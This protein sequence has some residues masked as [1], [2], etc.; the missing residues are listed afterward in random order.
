MATQP[1][2]DRE[3]PRVVGQ[4]RLGR[5]A[6]P[7]AP[8]HETHVT[9]RCRARRRARSARASGRSA[10]SSAAPRCTPRRRRPSSARSR[11]RGS[12]APRRGRPRAPGGA[13]RRSRAR[14]GG[15]PTAAFATTRKSASRYAQIIR[16]ID[17]ADAGERGSGERAQRHPRGHDQRLEERDLL[18]A[19][20]SRPASARRRSRT[21]GRSSRPGGTPR[22]R[23]PPSRTTAAERAVVTA[24]C[25][26][27]RGRWRLTG[28][29]RSRSRSIDV[30]DHVD[31]AG[32]RAEDD[33]ARPPRATSR[34]ASRARAP[35]RNGR[36]T[37][38][39]LTHC[40]GRA[41]TATAAK[42]RETASPSA[43]VDS[44]E[45]VDA[46]CLHCKGLRVRGATVLIGS[47]I[48]N[49]RSR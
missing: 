16:N 43:G 34:A 37:T 47:E 48:T 21:S 9:R 28:C 38:R 15:T 26:E 45:E 7:A 35:K 20:P 19:G 25:P 3:Q 6:S 33:D 5:V 18:R 17:G 23:P 13:R 46:M 41:E 12:R 36:A 4:K 27:A 22:A 14:R 2:D 8:V 32:D 10:R 24:S 31:S 29:A 44:P 30:V 49:R 1:D 40:G 39:F 42:A 11:R